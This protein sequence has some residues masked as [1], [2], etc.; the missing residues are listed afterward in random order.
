MEF[1]NLDSSLKHLSVN[2]VCFNIEEKLKIKLALQQLQCD[3]HPEEIYLW[4]KIEGK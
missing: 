3:C 1:T 4:G 2:G